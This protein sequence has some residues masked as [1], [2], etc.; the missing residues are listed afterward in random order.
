M[1]VT[2]E[3]VGLDE[4]LQRLE[5][6]QWSLSQAPRKIVQ[7]ASK[8]LKEAM[9]HEAPERTGALKRGIHYR[10]FGTAESAYARFY[11]DEP[12]AFFVIEGTAAHDIYPSTK[13]A[14]FWVGADHPVAFVHH[15][16]T[17]A[18]PFPERAMEELERVSAALLGGIGEQ[19]VQG[20]RISAA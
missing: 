10:T 20:E 13:Q 4:V 9:L 2:I 7:D 16:G 11:D 6:M 5:I 3:V 12:Y 18:N 15:P 19:I 1:P 17:K 8:I 14:L